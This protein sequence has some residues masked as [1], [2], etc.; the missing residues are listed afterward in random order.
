MPS[1]R[2]EHFRDDIENVFDLHEE[3][4]QRPEIAYGQTRHFLLTEH[5]RQ[6][7]MTLGKRDGIGQVGPA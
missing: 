3:P 1:E 5:C 2:N 7:L 6:A 4:G